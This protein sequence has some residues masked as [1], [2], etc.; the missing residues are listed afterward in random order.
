[1]NHGTCDAPIQ[2]E[3]ELQPKLTQLQQYRCYQWVKAYVDALFNDREVTLIR[4]R[5]HHANPCS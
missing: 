1:M 4:K 2:N 3:F 5:K